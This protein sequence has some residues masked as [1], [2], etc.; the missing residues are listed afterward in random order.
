MSSDSQWT[1]VDDPSFFDD[2]KSPRVRRRR[3]AA[4]EPWSIDQ[5]LD[6]LVLAATAPMAL[7]P[8]RFPPEAYWVALGLL[9]IP[10]VVRKSATGRLMAMAPAV[11]PVLFL[12]VVSLPIGAWTAP[13]FWGDT[14]PELVRAVWGMAVL[15]GVLN[16]CAEG[17]VETGGA[18]QV[19]VSGHTAVAT[20]AYFAL[21]LGF[22]VAGLLALQ[23]P[24]KLPLLSNLVDRLAA[25]VEAR[26]GVMSG[27]NPN[28]VAGLAV[29]F[30]PLALALALAP[31]RGGDGG[32]LGG[33][34]QIAVRVAL[35]AIGLCFGA[36]VLLT[37]SRTALLATGVALLLVFVLAG[38]RGW[39]PLLLVGIVAAATLDVFGG[40]QLVELWSVRE[41]P[42]V[43]E[44]GGQAQGV[45]AEILSDRNVAGRIVLWRRA[46]H[47]LADDPL[48]GMGL[49]GFLVRS[50]ESYPGM[51]DWRPDPDMAHVHNLVLQTGL[52]S[53]IPGMLAF[54][55][56]LVC[57]A[58]DLV[59][60]WSG[61]ASGSPA[62]FWAIGMIGAFTAFVAYNM[63][64]AVTVGARPAVAYWYLLGLIAGTAAALRAGQAARSVGAWG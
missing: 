26:F 30:T 21:G 22:T 10:Y 11:W 45:W 19:A 20:M 16:W 43:D 38:R 24:N 49:A 54:V 2:P 33:A 23:S 63:L 37:Q 62:R 7:F 36:V 55:A 27:F 1:A 3:R 8:T 25:V 64:D 39:L 40:S 57:I 6:P 53:G 41:A 34:G 50:Q 13:D 32:L 48:T 18:G 29:L 17:E 61:T 28:R 9:I 59:G 14:W 58:F 42:G 52:D 47:G 60:L 5:L 12:L 44:Q 46:L 56:L 35:L 15:L 51:P 31:R 4:R